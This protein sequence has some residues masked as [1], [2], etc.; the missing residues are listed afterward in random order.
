MHFRQ[1]SYSQYTYHN[2]NRIDILS[3][4]FP[5]RLLSIVEEFLNKIYHISDTLHSL[6][7]GSF[8]GG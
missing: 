4:K 7:H 3:Q 6:W 1:S 2:T 5:N 8:K